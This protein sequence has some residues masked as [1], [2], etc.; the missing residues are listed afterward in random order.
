MA[1]KILELEGPSK[2]HYFQG[3]KIMTNLQTQKENCLLWTSK[4]SR[5]YQPI[6]NSAPCLSLQKYFQMSKL[7]LYHN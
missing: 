6:Y 2:G 3:G 1:D 7:N 5:N 4:E